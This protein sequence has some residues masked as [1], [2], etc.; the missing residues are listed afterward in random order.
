[1]ENKNLTNRLV[2]KYLTNIFGENNPNAKTFYAF[3][4]NRLLIYDSKM[5][6]IVIIPKDAI[7]CES[8][9]VSI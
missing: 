9:S 1:M 2:K 3:D 7:I 6:P 5:N 4:A 8:V